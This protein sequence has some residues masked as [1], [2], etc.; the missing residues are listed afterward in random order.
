MVVSDRRIDWRELARKAQGLPVL[1]A[2]A[3]KA[4]IVLISK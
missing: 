4:D 2:L 1:S 3:L